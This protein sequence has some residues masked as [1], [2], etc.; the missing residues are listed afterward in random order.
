MR[1][2]ALCFVL[3]TWTAL[4]QSDRGAIEG[5]V[6][7]PVAGVHANAPIQVKNVATG[8]V[9]KAASSKTGA[10][11][12][13][14]LPAGKYDVT[15]GIQGLRPF[16]QRD[17]TVEAAKTL[18]L[19]I[20]LQEGTQLSTLGEDP[21]AAVANSAMHKPPSGPTPRT[22]D[23]KPDL[24]GVWW[25]AVDLDPGKPEWLPWAEKVAKQRTDNNNK[26]SPQAHCLPP[27]L[28]RVGPL[29]ELV[30]S[31]A[32]LVVINDDASPGFNQI[33]IDGR[34]HPSDPNPA[35][36]GHSIGSWDGD[37]LV[38]DRVGFIDQVW[39]DQGSHPH[40]DKLHIIERYRRPDLGHLE[41]EITVI[42]PETLAKPWTMKRV[43]DL[44]QAEISEF[45]CTENNRDVEH[46]VG[47]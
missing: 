12:L 20:H 39:L 2:P 16:Q 47:K 13:A 42:D 10:Y 29:Y 27:A 46:M 5:T 22:G 35:W 3:L 40:T 6:Q 30:Q 24:S 32:F 37:T 38:V 45:I 15:V 36:Y 19:D 44:A 18:R 43:S 1:V 23:G 4:G 31:K 34:G 26:D 8:T 7:D 28:T 21:T 11:T 14:D 17:I 25:R 33:Y 41:T 9:Y